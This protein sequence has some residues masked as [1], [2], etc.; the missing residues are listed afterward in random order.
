MAGS[1]ALADGNGNGS[2]SMAGHGSAGS[3]AMAAGTGNLD[4]LAT[5]DYNERRA[6]IQRYGY[7]SQFAIWFIEEPFFHHWTLNGWGNVF[8]INMDRRKAIK[9]QEALLQV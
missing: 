9:E 1:S 2:F 7:S 3:V 4:L 8:R 5:S 6:I